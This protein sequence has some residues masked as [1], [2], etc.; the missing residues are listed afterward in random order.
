VGSSIELMLEHRQG[1][2]T[3]RGRV[4]HLQA[5]GVGVAFSDPPETFLGFVRG[6]IDDLLTGAAEVQDRRAEPRTSIE[7]QVVWSQTSA[8]HRGRLRNITSQ[9]ALIECD[10]CPEIESEVFVYLPGYAYDVASPRPSEARGCAAR[11]M[12]RLRYGFGVQFV[13]PSAEF[14][15]AIDGVIRAARGVGKDR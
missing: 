13:E 9:G 2:A 4:T 5:D 1:S 11:V 14:L 7:V 8:E 15:M 6:V 12:H 10:R 3:V